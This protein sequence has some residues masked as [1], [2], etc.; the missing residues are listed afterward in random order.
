[1]RGVAKVA[2]ED[3]DEAI[4]D[5]Y[6]AT[7][8]NPNLQNSYMRGVSKMVQGDYDGAISDCSSAVAQNPANPENYYPA[9]SPQSQM[10]VATSAPK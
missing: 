4:A 7:A 5:Y 10:T 8:S 6:R 1:M 2:K 3:Y 9:V